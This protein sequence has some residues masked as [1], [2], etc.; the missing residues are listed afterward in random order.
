[1]SGSMLCVPALPHHRIR[2]L[3]LHIG[4]SNSSLALPSPQELSGYFQECFLIGRP[5]KPFKV[6]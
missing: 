5:Q 6:H 1:M 4:I 2:G 3:K